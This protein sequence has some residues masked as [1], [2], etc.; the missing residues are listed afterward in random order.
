[1]GA[2][3]VLAGGHS[4]RFGDRDKALAT[5]EGTPLV[6]HVVERVTGAEAVEEVVINCRAEQRPV[7]REAVG[8]AATPRFAVDPIPDGGPVAGMR[9]GLRTV[10]EQ[11]TFVVGCDMPLVDAAFV[12]RLFDSAAGDGAV[13]RDAEGWQP[14]CSVY[15]TAAARTATTRTLACGSRRMHDVLARLDV[16]AVDTDDTPD[17]PG[18]TYSVDT[19]AALDTAASALDAQSQ[20]N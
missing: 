17:E 16:V 9:T 18:P 5:L 7:I 4:R 19:P 1:M 8:D 13:P 15:D 14:L 12:E 10:G 11:R 6:R 3:L 20:V 2:A